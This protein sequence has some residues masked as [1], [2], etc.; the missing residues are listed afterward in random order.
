MSNKIRKR[1]LL[2]HATD[3][4]KETSSS[5]L[6]TLYGVQSIDE[7][8]CDDLSKRLTLLGNSWLP[9]SINAGWKTRKSSRENRIRGSGNF[10]NVANDC[11]DRKLHEARDSRLDIKRDIPETLTLHIR[12]LSPRILIVNNDREHFRNSLSFRRNS[13]Y[14]WSGRQSGSNHVE[15]SLQGEDRRSCSFF[16]IGASTIRTLD[17]FRGNLRGARNN[18]MQGWLVAI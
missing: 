11:P 8:A 5:T 7:I 6:Y 18:K 14:D 2:H 10:T 12:G 16:A 3:D 1:L 17:N 9:S 13:M 4:T 15:I